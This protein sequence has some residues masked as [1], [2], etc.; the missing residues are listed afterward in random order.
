MVMNILFSVK[1]FF[2]L[3]SQFSC[4][5]EP[6]ISDLVHYRLNQLNLTLMY[7]VLIQVAPCFL[8]I[9]QSGQV[10]ELRKS[11]NGPLY[12]LLEQ[13]AKAS[14]GSPFSGDSTFL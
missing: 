5:L 14:L 8:N 1:F 4:L 11:L 6:S 12:F 9:P 2:H 3:Y 7:H 13:K 10:W